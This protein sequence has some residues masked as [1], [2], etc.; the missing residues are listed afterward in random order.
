MLLVRS[1]E[2]DDVDPLASQ[3]ADATT[4]IERTSAMA[5]E[6]LAVEVASNK[7]GR[8]PVIVVRVSRRGLRKQN[9]PPVTI[10]TISRFI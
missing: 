4:Q 10:A 9:G 5:D 2:G 6:V 3:V 7:T 8:I 1:A